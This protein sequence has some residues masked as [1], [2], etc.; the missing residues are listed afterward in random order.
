MIPNINTKLN[1]ISVIQTAFGKIRPVKIREV[2][3]TA[4]S[5]SPLLHPDLTY[6]R[7]FTGRIGKAQGHFRREW[8]AMSMIGMV[9]STLMNYLGFRALVSSFPWAALPMALMLEGYLLGTSNLIGKGNRRALPWL[10]SL[11]IFFGS[12]SVGLSVGGLN[13]GETQ[14]QRRLNLPAYQLEDAQKAEGSFATAAAG[15]QAAALGRI[16]NELSFFTETSRATAALNGTQS[17]FARDREERRSDLVA[18]Q[19][20]WQALDF[21]NDFASAKTADLTWTILRHEFAQIQPLVA[22]TEKL[23]SGKA[24]IPLPAFPVAPNHDAADSREGQNDQT[25]MSQLMHPTL[26]WLVIVPIALAM[27]VAPM[28]IA[29]AMRAIESGDRR[30]DEEPEG[31]GPEE[32]SG[33]PSPDDTPEPPLDIADD[34]NDRLRRSR[35]AGDDRWLDPLASSFDTAIAAR[36]EAHRVVEIEALTNLT[37]MRSLEIWE[38][39]A[40]ILRDAAIRTGIKPG[41][42]EKHLDDSFV[43]LQKRYSDEMQIQDGEAARRV[44]RILNEQERLSDEQKRLTASDR[45]AVAKQIA[46]IQSNLEALGRSQSH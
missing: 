3:D 31:D 16:R 39:E 22:D 43:R 15:T 33:E 10:V 32:P 1:I 4:S 40:A 34:F 14:V 41:T 36:V 25:G 37:F 9:M 19:T 12:L 5:A 44:Q 23:T 24:P 20:K 45:L 35:R 38:E 28:A 17:G 18:L 8:L 11:A 42:V 21:S 7:E 2:T 27:D 13:A 26:S 6:S 29:A 30:G 46:E